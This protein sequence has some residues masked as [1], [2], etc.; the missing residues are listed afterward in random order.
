MRKI[1]KAWQEKKLLRPGKFEGIPQTPLL[2]I[3]I[4]QFRSDYFFHISNTTIR[5]LST[6]ITCQTLHLFYQVNV[7]PYVRLSYLAT[8]LPILY[9]KQKKSPGFI[10][11][12]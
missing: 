4:L 11:P 9:D 8:Q 6:W 12:F 1:C 5:T 10:F 2:G 7:F 3:F